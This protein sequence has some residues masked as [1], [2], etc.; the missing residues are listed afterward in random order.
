MIHSCTIFISSLLW[1]LWLGC[2]GQGMSGSRGS[3]R[4]LRA[5][6]WGIS[7]VGIM[8]LSTFSEIVC[9]V[10]WLLVLNSPVPLSDWTLLWICK[11]SGARALRGDDSGSGAPGPRW[12]DIRDIINNTDIVT[13]TQP[14]CHEDSSI[15]KWWMLKHRKLEKKTDRNPAKFVL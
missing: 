2:W 5:G 4:L 12:S 1:T 7:R 10:C 15:I 6:W 13:F 11:V 3:D 14:T 8:V 9:F